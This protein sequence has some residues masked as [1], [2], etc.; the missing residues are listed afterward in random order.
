MASWRSLS[1]QLL[2][3][4]LRTVARPYYYNARVETLITTEYWF[5]GELLRFQEKPQNSTV[6]SKVRLLVMMYGFCCGIM[7]ISRVVIKTAS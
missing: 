5:A 7:A 6:L 1:E 2:T 3:V 4:V